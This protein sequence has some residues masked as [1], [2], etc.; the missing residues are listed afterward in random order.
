MALDILTGFDQE[1]RDPGILLQPGSD[2]TAGE[3]TSDDDVVC[4]FVGSHG[5]QS[6]HAEL[7]M[8]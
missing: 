3:S 5:Y 7:R 1:N 2:D 4:S 8:N 6:V